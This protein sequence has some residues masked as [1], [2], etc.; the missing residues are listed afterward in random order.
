MLTGQSSEQLPDARAVTGFALESGSAV[1]DGHLKRGAGVYERCM[2]WVALQ[3]G[4]DADA[5]IGD[6]ELKATLARGECDDP[7]LGAIT[8]NNDI[9]LKFA[10]GA[11]QRIAKVSW[12]P[13]SD[14][15]VCE[16]HA[17]LIPDVLLGVG[18]T[19]FGKRKNS[20]NI[21][22]VRAG[23]CPLGQGRTNRIEPH[24]LDG[25]G[26]VVMRSVFPCHGYLDEGSER[27]VSR[28]GNRATIREVPS[29]RFEQKAV[30]RSEIECKAKFGVHNCSSPGSCSE[31]ER[32][33]C[34][35]ENIVNGRLILK[36]RCWL[37]DT[38]A[39]ITA[40][41]GSIERIL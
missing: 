30:G 5:T 22:V 19:P 15:R 37:G 8:V 12:K 35:E 13:R 9:V 11:S 18:K 41:V 21:L 40:L 33:E 39:L 14:R 2:P 6:H 7:G 1:G 28:Q 16:A 10:H 29:V 25:H 20:E 4:E 3:T 23:D 26:R 36:W 31:T 38:C 27:L 32:C 34:S 24:V 17:P